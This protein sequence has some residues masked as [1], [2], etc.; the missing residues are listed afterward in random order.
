MIIVQ[1][2]AISSNKL[3]V[4]TELDFQTSQLQVAKGEN[5]TK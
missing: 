4:N 5:H 3:K 2:C 1:R